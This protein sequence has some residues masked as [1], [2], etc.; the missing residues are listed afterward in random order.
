MP[1]A[2]KEPDKIQP[3]ATSENAE[4]IQVSGNQQEN[5]PGL[6]TTKNEQGK[7]VLDERKLVVMQIKAGLKE[8]IDPQVVL[9]DI[10]RMNVLTQKESIKRAEQKSES[11]VIQFPQSQAQP[12]SQEQARQAA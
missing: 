8:G 1:E 10:A 12:A 9:H 3:Q 7:D 5:S 4:P 2:T 11:K 6:P